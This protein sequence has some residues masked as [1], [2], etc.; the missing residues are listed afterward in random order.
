M[1]TTLLTCP[2]C[3]HSVSRSASNCPGCG[4]VLRSGG[5]SKGIAALLSLVIPGAGQIYQ[6]RVITGL[7]LFV[8][9][10][11]TI[12]FLVGLI[13]WIIAVLDTLTYS[14]KTRAK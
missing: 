2:D 7:I 14:P 13:F 9:F 5:T 11:T 1:S 8:L 6:G 4:A 10:V 3:G 12:W